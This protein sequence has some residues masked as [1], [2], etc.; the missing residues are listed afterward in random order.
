MGRK[1]DPH[2]HDTVCVQTN[3]W[4]TAGED[5]EEL[6]D[7]AEGLDDDAEGVPVGEEGRILVLE[8]EGDPVT[9]AEA[10][11]IAKRTRFMARAERVVTIFSRPS[12]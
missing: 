5:E 6:N 12:C 1:S 11:W 2:T 10:W 8:A 4:G 9:D 3:C 7:D